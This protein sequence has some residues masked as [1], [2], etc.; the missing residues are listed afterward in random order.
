[1]T[2]SFD[3]EF[4]DFLETSLLTIKK[5][6]GITDTDVLIEHVMKEAKMKKNLDLQSQVEFLALVKEVMD[7]YKFAATKH[8]HQ[9]RK[10]GEP[11]IHHPLF[12]ALN[13][14]YQQK[15]DGKGFRQSPIIAALLHDTVEDTNTTFSDINSSFGSKVQHIVEKLTNHPSWESWKSEDLLTHRE[16]SALQFINASRDENALRVKYDDRYHNLETIRHMPPQKQVNKILDTLEVG[17]IEHAERLTKFYFLL[18][19]YL[20]ISRYLTDEN[21]DLYTDEPAHWKEKRQEA[22]K[23]I[24]EILQRNTDYFDPKPTTL[25]A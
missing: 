13:E 17:F 25:Q 24:K 1:M 22:L 14:I 6:H 12:V 11:Y 4:L 7:A 21:I 18:Q 2:N 19:L 20:T 10:S 8:A 5:E 3:R 23:M 16:Q 9:K 15:Q